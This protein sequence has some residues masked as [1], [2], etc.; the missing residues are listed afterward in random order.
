MNRTL[1]TLMAL[2]TTATLLACS[3]PERDRPKAQAPL[4]GWT[5][6]VDGYQ[7]GGITAAW[8]AGISGK[9]RSWALVGGDGKDGLILELSGDTWVRHTVPGARLLWWVHGDAQGN[10]AAVGDGGTL[11]TWRAGDATPK[12]TQ[13]SSLKSAG[14]ALYG[15]WFAPG[16]EQLWVSGGNPK[17]SAGS[18]VLWRIPAS[19]LTAGGS[20]A[21]ATAAAKVDLG[22]KQGT[23]FKVI[24]VGDERWAVGDGGH[25]W[26]GKGVSWQR[27]ATIATDVLIGVAGSKADGLVTVGGRGAGVVA[28]R[29]SSGWKQVAG[30][31]DA[32]ISGLSGVTLLPEAEHPGVAIVAGSYGFL[33]QQDDTTSANDLPSLDPPLTSLTLHGA[34]ADPY[35]QVVVGGSFDNPAAPVVGTVLMRGAPLPPLP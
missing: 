12:V 28:R 31:K 22:D 24:G 14:V 17:A 33:G 34:W 18:G 1:M 35:T 20:D 6:L 7:R 23:L 2:L 29:D 30:G 27:E 9:K 25:I 26:H 3:P 16:A 8:S 13:I 21:A 11:V 5:A 15:V 32:W 19:S 10:R 4:E